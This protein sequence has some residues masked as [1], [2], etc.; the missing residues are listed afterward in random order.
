MSSYLIRPNPRI[1]FNV[2]QLS[3]NPNLFPRAR[4]PSLSYTIYLEH[5]SLYFVEKKLLLTE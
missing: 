4:D 3:A 2:L 1:N 5:F